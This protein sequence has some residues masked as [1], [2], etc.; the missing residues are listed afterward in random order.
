[1][2]ILGEGLHDY[3]D[4]LTANDDP[5]VFTREKENRVSFK[6]AKQLYGIEPDYRDLH[7][8]DE[9]PNSVRAFIPRP[10]IIT[11]GGKDYYPRFL[12]VIVAGKH[13]RGICLH[14]NGFR[15]GYDR[16]DL[17]F[18]TFDALKTWATDNGLRIHERD[19]KDKW[20]MRREVNKPLAEYFE[21][22]HD[23]TLYN[24]MADNKIVIMRCELTDHIDLIHNTS[25][26]WYINGVG[27][28]SI[29]FYKVMDAYTLYQEIDMWVSGVMVSAGRPMVKISDKDRIHKHGFDGWS[30]RKH[31]DDPK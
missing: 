1:M 24:T 31:K 12:H 4:S 11:K 3:Y 2:R 6:D 18:W 23:P 27:L 15:P 7:I 13:Y 30:F 19:P 29:E 8:N 5:V 20:Y 17:F 16:K 9:K 10:K 25:R 21:V 14:D 26:F 22:K 28:D